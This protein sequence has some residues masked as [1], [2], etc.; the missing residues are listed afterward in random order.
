MLLARLWRLSV[1]RP[2]RV[3]HTHN[4]HSTHITTKKIKGKTKTKIG[5]ATIQGFKAHRV[6][7][8]IVEPYAFWFFF[9]RWCW[10][11]KWLRLCG[12]RL[13]RASRVQCL[14]WCVTD[15]CRRLSSASRTGMW[16]CTCVNVYMCVRLYVCMHRCLAWPT[17]VGTCPLRVIQVC[18][19]VYVYIR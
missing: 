14:M 10:R 1:C 15:L 19:R 17:C 2:S 6:L 4:S 16:M 12:C 5:V 8:I 7:F 9:K 3:H 13:L 11:S 18:I